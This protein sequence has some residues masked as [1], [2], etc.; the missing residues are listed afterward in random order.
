M[1]YAPAEQM[2]IERKLLLTVMEAAEYSNLG[3][4]K[5]RDMARDS[6]CKWAIFNGRKLLIK[7]AAFAE[8]LESSNVI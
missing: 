2:P 6:G 8:Y 5:I 4:D 7:R 3:R 1:G